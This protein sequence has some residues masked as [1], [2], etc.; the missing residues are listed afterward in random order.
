MF[1][2]VNAQETNEV[3]DTRNTTVGNIEVGSGGMWTRTIV[4]NNILGTPYLFSNWETLATIH[5]GDG[6]QYSITNLNYDTKINRFVSKVSLDSV[7]VFEASDLKEAILNNRRFKRY[8]FND[9][10]EYYQI[11]ASSKGKEILKKNFKAIKR[12][13]KDPL[14]AKVSKDKYYLKTKYFLNSKNGVREF[15][16]KKKTFL[17]IFGNQSPK[18]KKYIKRNKLSIKN[19]I[20]IAK[21]FKYY[22]GL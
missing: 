22:D 8:Y 17:K 4:D 11:I 18:V 5:T 3:A 16:M 21:I 7:F 10:Y 15:K 6:K 14:T 12:G 20:D 19:D 2:I 1:S 9:V 13:K